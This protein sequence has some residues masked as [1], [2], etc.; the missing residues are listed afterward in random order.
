M[1]DARPRS[2][3]ES[4]KSFEGR[5]PPPELRVQPWCV[6]VTY[7]DN[8]PKDSAPDRTEIHNIMIEVRKIWWDKGVVVLANEADDSVTI[9][10]L[11][12]WEKTKRTEMTDRK[13]ELKNN[14]ANRE[15][16]SHPAHMD[17]IFVTSFGDLGLTFTDK[18][19]YESSLPL[20]PCKRPLAIVTVKGCWGDGKY[21]QRE[22]DVEAFESYYEP[23]GIALDTAHEIGHALG[24][25]HSKPSEI[26]NL[27][28]QN[29]YNTIYKSD[30]PRQDCEDKIKT[31]VAALCKHGGCW[32]QMHGSQ[33]NDDQIKKVMPAVRKIREKYKISAE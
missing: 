20:E 14:F 16:A 26:E 17:L 22:T 10:L 18:D 24:L 12:S 25:K 19:I 28:N 6:N 2:Q 31:G 15:K 27:M 1:G 33:L 9:S 7:E 30:R 32:C 8:T 4:G 3:S 21:T 11:K 29:L 5:I 23:S 13:K